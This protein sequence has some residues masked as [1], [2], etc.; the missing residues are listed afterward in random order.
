MMLILINVTV[1]ICDNWKWRIV[2]CLNVAS[3]IL[4]V[5]FKVVRFALGKPE[6]DEEDNYEKEI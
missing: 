2:A 4:R 6:L 5:G 1:A 3:C